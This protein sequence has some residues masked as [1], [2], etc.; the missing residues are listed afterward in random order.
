MNATAVPSLVELAASA[1]KPLTQPEKNLL[2]KI[3]ST[4]IVRVRT[5]PEVCVNRYSGAQHTLNPL[6]AT[7][8]AFIIKVSDRQLFDMIP[9]K[10]NTWDRA[11]YLFLKLWPSEYY[12][13]L[14]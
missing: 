6:A 10:V 5:A 12:D 3:Q 8:F 4:N 7:L 14:D 13:L 1:P 2:E 9:G 11:R